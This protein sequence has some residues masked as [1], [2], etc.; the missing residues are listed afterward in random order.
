ME[1]NEHVIKI[2]KSANIDQPLTLGNDYEIKARVHCQ[3]EGVDD[4][5]DGTFNKVYNLQLLGEVDISNEEKHIIKARV[6]GSSSQKWRW[7][8]K[9]MG[10]DYDEI[11][12]I[13]L[14]HPEEVIK[15]LKG[16]K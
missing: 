1:I 7:S 6:K 12:N 5:H 4:N 16:L 2:G 15:F 14:S 13:Q 11:M 9:S 10:E 3:K 8:V